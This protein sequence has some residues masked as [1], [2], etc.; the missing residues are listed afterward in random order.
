M[1]VLFL[2]EI[3]SPNKKKH[4]FETFTKCWFFKIF[5]L[6]FI[7]T[8][9][10]V[11]K[12]ERSHFDKINNNKEFEE[13]QFCF[14][15]YIVLFGIHISLFNV[16]MLVLSIYLYW[17]LSVHFRFCSFVLFCFFLSFVR[18]DYTYRLN[19]FFQMLYTFPLNISIAFQWFDAHFHIGLPFKS[20]VWLCFIF[21]SFFQNFIYDMYKSFNPLKKKFKCSKRL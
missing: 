9:S 4:F 3:L 8:L 6:K 17:I 1:N 21:L 19:T 7:L 16:I 20:I 12:N 5:V 2:T 14:C 10:A 11:N 18:F 15:I 13:N